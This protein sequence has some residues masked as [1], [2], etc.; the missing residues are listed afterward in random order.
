MNAILPP[1]KT[2]DLVKSVEVTRRPSVESRKA[3][4]GGD[5]AIL[6]NASNKSLQTPE[7]SKETFVPI[8]RNTSFKSFQTIEDNKD[9]VFENGESGLDRRSASWLLTDEKKV[10]SI[11]SLLREDL[12]G[13]YV[14]VK[15]SFSF[16]SEVSDSGISLG[17]SFSSRKS[18]DS[19]VS[20]HRIRNSD[21]DDNSK[22]SSTLVR[23]NSNP[24]YSDLFSLT[25]NKGTGSVKAENSQPCS[26]GSTQTL[27]KHPM[28]K[29]SSTSSSLPGISENVYSEVTFSSSS[30]VKD[31]QQRR[32][33]KATPLNDYNNNKDKAC[34][35]SYQPFT[36]DNPV[37]SSAT[38]NEKLCKEDKHTNEKVLFISNELD[39]ETKSLPDTN[40]DTAESYL[41]NI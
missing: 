40:Y 6:R 3:I 12:W 24:K 36:N 10:H 18:D 29:I 4:G 34:I 37:D 15:P 33:I 25:S 19:P 16:R 1:R 13:N 41:E 2:S 31:K 8:S 35:Q 30:E 28:R 17:E 7:E 9:D 39:N 22:D 21:S 11:R 26:A 27:E 23:S 38:K 5:T 20:C 32:L 14:K